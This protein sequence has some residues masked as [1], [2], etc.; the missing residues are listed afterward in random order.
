MEE[1]DDLKKQGWFLN[2]AEGLGNE[3]EGLEKKKEGENRLND[4]R[5]RG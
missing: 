1:M 4:E 5:L 2:D 3:Q